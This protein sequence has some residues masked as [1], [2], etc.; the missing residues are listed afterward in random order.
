MERWM[1]KVMASEI[2][3]DDLEIVWNYW[4]NPKYMEASELKEILNN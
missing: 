3:F 1:K 2:Y 4:G